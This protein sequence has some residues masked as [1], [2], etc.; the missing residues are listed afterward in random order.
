VGDDSRGGWG[1]L[2][3]ATLALIFVGLVLTNLTMAS[4]WSWRTFASSQGFADTTTDMLK[5]PAVREEIAHQIVGVLEEEKATSRV[6]VN[7][8]PIVEAIVAEVVATEPF[9][10]VF[11]AGVREL[12]SSIVAGQR[13]RLLVDVDDTA[14]LVRDGLAVAYPDLE[15]PDVVLDVAVGI[16]QSTP[17]DTAIRISSLAGWL[18]APFAVGALACFA[19]ALRRARDRR[20]AFEVIGLGF[21]LTGVVHFALLAVGLTLAASLGDDPRERTALRAVFWSATHLINVQA[22]VAITIGTVLALAAA[23]TGTGQIRTRLAMLRQRVGSL[24]AMPAWRAVACLAAIAAGYFAMRWPEA[25]TSIVIRVAA[26]LAFVAGAIGMLDLLGSVNWGV[27]GGAQ[28]QRRGRQVAIGM[29]AA[30]SITSTVMLFGGLAFVRAV[31]APKVAHAAMADVGCNGHIELCDKPLDEVVFA[32]THN[33]MAA[34]WQGFLV[35]SQRGGIGAQLANGVRAF[36]LDLHYGAHVHDLVR[37]DLR[38][39]AKTTLGW[40]NLSADERAATENVLALASGVPPDAERK[41]YLCHL[42]C[43]LGAT[44]AVEELRELHDYL[45]ENPN[46]VVVLVLEDFVDPVDG[47]AVLERSG[48]AKHAWSWEPGEP[49]PT[50]GDM[51]QRGKNVLVLVENDG[52][53]EPWYIPAYNILQDTPYRFEEQRDFS[54]AL[55]RGDATN[56]LFL[57][58]HWIT[59]DP[60]DPNM[61]AE[62]NARDVLLARAEACDSEHGHMPNIIAVDFYGTGDLFDVVDVL[63]GVAPP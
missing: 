41:V 57:V 10:G 9:Q 43:E 45:R 38:S 37:T 62:V 49:V 7:A 8:R 6:A 14:P 20:R 4:V 26:F 39:E 52:G 30:V 25:S 54:C 36:L 3:R 21:V 27:D 28:F 63:N 34:S 17:V 60:P 50:L 42:K 29:T 22:K 35:P 12:H 16:S 33:S 5:E 32:G 23:Q 44:P 1:G 51:I 61:A 53:A 19:M 59:A 55:G 11:H 40:A 56:P 2:G 46:E 47:V 24:L 58:N 31:Q 48:L 15:L 13:S 18:A